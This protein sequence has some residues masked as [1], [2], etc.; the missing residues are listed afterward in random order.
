VIEQPDLDA[1]EAILAVTSH[2]FFIQNKI[3]QHALAHWEGVRQ[4]NQDL[5]STRFSNRLR[6]CLIWPVSSAKL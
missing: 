3:D 5:L 2:I 1:I 4:A 6:H